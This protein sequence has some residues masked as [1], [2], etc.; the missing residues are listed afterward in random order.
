MLRDWIEQAAAAHGDDIYLADARGTATL[1]YAELLELV[2]DTETRLDRAGLV[3]GARIGV[4]LAEPL[5]YAAALVAIV[6]AGRVAVPLDPGA[7]DSDVARVLDVARPAATVTARGGRPA[8]EAARCVAG[9]ATNPFGMIRFDFDLAD[10]VPA[11]PPA[12]GGFS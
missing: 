10:S 6:A 11:P 7:P 2:R 9:E 8:R 5:Q 12:L 1:T 3:P 4:R